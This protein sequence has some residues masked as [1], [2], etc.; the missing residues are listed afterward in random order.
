MLFR[1]LFE[2]VSSAYTYLIGCEGSGEAVLIDP[3][4]E[5]VERDLQLLA[6]LGL[7]LRFTVET[8]RSAGDCLLCRCVKNSPEDRPGLWRWRGRISTNESHAIVRGKNDV[9]SRIE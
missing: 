2:P 9:D 4:L 7:T 1:Q 3:V 6:A 5:T 8:H